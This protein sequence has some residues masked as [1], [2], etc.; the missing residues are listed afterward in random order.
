MR[1]P[2]AGHVLV[3]DDDSDLRGMLRDYLQ[4]EGFQCRTAD[5]TDA[6][7]RILATEPC[8][9]VILDLMLP[10]ENGLAALRRLR[11]SSPV[12]VIMLTARGSEME[13]VL[14]LELGADDYLSKPFNPQELVAR[15]RAILRRTAT[16]PAIP[17]PLRIDELEVHPA[18]R[19]VFLA[20][21][22]V[23]LTSMEYNVLEVLARSAGKVVSR[24]ELYR[25]ALA[26]QAGP[27]DR[28]IDVHIAS[29]R[30]KLGERSDGTERIATV[31][32]IGYVLTISGGR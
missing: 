2:S 20:G 4:G 30:R 17:A 18:A 26:R 14:G 27:Y 29:L 12:P 19:R 24:D 1:E 23:P 9:L 7:F 16:E 15:I 11:E 8:K 6:M 10:G 25:R 5:T 21:R 13:R 31:R 28:S 22:D 3:V 32:A